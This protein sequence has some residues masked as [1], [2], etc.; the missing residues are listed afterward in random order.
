[1]T[2]DEPVEVVGIARP[3]RIELCSELLQHIAPAP[4]IALSRK[5]RQ[6]LL[7]LAIV[8][9]ALRPGVVEDQPLHPIGARR[10]ED[11]AR[12]SF[13]CNS[14][15]G[16]TLAADGVHDCAQI[17]HPR[18]GREPARAVREPDAAGI[19]DDE[20][21]PFREPVAELGEPG[22]LPERVEVGE[23]REQNEVRGP[24][25]TTW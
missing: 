11:G 2:P 8:E 1:V 20:A 19:D 6:R 13:L 21:P 22:R 5:A 14:E 12:R 7:A 23:E 10:G 18:F 17:V 9:H 24:S 16:R 3:L 25:P 15:Q 4:S